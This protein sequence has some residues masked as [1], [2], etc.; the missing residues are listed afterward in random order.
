MCFFFFLS[1]LRESQGLLKI[2]SHAVAVER[3]AYGLFSLSA[4]SGA[5]ARTAI[6][7]LPFF[8]VNKKLKISP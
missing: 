6:H 3:E 1:F 7:V 4:E 8:C 2:N 5:T